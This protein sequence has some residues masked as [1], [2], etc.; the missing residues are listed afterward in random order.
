MPETLYE[1][2]FVKLNEDVLVLKRYHVFPLLKHKYVL[3]KNIKVVWFED[4]NCGK[5]PIR[6]AWGKA[7]D[8][9]LYWAL[10]Y[11][12]CLP[13]DK[14]GKS[15]V[16]IDAEDGLKKGFTVA[17]VQSFLASLRCIC[18]M[19]LIVVDNLNLN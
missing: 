6:R 17:D 19:S 15:D 1:D 5:F 8:H 9:E 18:P 10:D 2:E 11:R 13:G 4:Q 3:T 7:R 16:I 14:A 12:R